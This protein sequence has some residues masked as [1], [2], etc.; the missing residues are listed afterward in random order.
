MRGWRLVFIDAAPAGLSGDPRRRRG[1]RASARAARHGRSPRL[2]RR[3]RQR[4]ERGVVLRTDHVDRDAFQRRRR[5]FTGGSRGGGGVDLRPSRLRHARRRAGSAPGCGAWCGVHNLPKRSAKTS[6]ESTIRSLTLGGRGRAG[7]ERDMNALTRPHASAVTTRCVGTGVGERRCRRVHRPRT[8][9]STR[10]SSHRTEVAAS[11]GTDDVEHV[12]RRAAL[13]VAGS[14]IAL[15]PLS[16]RADDAEDARRPP[17]PYAHPRGAGRPRQGER[18][19]ATR[20]GRFDKARVTDRAQPVPPH[21]AGVLLTVT[22]GPRAVPA[23]PD[24]T[25]SSPCCCCDP[26]TRPSTPWT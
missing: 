7:R 16:A 5:R 22:A 2:R 1:I 26:R 12:S 3:I 10:A 23:R 20:V 6:A 18:R 9:V 15:T 8:A 4:E 25:S 21:P 13:M 14:L 11:L 24:S 19:G 17:A